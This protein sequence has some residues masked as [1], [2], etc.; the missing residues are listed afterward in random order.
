[1]RITVIAT[2]IGLEEEQFSQNIHR[3][4]PSMHQVRRIAGFHTD[5]SSGQMELVEQATG[6]MGFSSYAGEISQDNSAR[7][8]VRNPTP[9]ELANWNETDDPVRITRKGSSSTSSLNP[10]YT[11]K[12]LDQDD[13]EIPTFLRRKAD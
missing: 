2:G 3:L 5:A 4:D 13:L 6:T 10:V 1:M 11:N 12:S 8:I 7:G 9:E